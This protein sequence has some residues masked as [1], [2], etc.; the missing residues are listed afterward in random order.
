M[1]EYGTAIKV[2][3]RKVT[4]SVKRTAACDRCGRCSHPDIAFGD[5]GTLIVEAISEGEIRPGDVVE[6]EMDTGEFLKASFLVWMLPLLSAGAGFG[7]GYV[8]GSSAG[9]GGLWGTVFSLAAA[10]VSFFWLHEYDKSSQRAGRYLPYA[11]PL[12]D[13]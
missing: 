2:Q 3:G 12:R 13:L 4:V 6:L 8:I 9:N 10:A 7:I 11:R 5:N 1:K